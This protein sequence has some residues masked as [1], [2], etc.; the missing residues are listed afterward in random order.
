MF[1]AVGARFTGPFGPDHDLTSPSGGPR[2]E[3]LTIH[4]FDK[5]EGATPVRCQ[6]R[7]FRSRQ[8]SQLMKLRNLLVVSLAVLGVV[9]LPATAAHALL[10][11]VSINFGP[12]ITGP[13]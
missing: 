10:V 7:T 9:A 4:Q 6:G 5:Y 8:E 13:D 11:K 3:P 2:T 12:T 1:K